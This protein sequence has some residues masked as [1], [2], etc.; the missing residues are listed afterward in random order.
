[1]TTNKKTNPVESSWSNFVHPKESWPHFFQNL[2]E[3]L[4]PPV[5]PLRT[6]PPSH[7]PPP[8]P[9]PTSVPQTSCKQ[10][11]RWMEDEVTIPM[12]KVFIDIA[13]SLGKQ[14]NVPYPSWPATATNPVS[15]KNKMKQSWKNRIPWKQEAV[16]THR[17]TSKSHDK[18]NKAQKL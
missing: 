18:V 16:R 1:M 14:T 9:S 17:K 8:Y 7:P 13:A 12:N 3:S 15:P 6:P 10:H 11:Q 5:T 2:G 4:P